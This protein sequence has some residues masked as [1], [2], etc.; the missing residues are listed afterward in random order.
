MNENELKR[1]FLTLVASGDRHCC[2]LLDVFRI[3]NES[4]K[5]GEHLL[6]YVAL[7]NFHH[8]LAA[9][10]APSE[11]VDERLFEEIGENCF[12]AVGSRFEPSC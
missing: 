7:E 3:W 1:A 2:G 12:L 9:L 10:S 6:D 5:N 4:V 11:D 8:E